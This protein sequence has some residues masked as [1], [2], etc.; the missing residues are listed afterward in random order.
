MVI[1]R[2]SMF[3]KIIEKY[4]KRMFADVVIGWVS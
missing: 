2:L 3:F 4:L 1:Q